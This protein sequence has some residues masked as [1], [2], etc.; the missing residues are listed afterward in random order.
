MVIASFST[1]SQNMLLHVLPPFF[2]FFFLPVLF[3]F[4]KIKPSSK[5]PKIKD[6]A[7][8]SAITLPK[9]YPLIGYYLAFKANAHRRIQWLSD[10]ILLSPAA[11][12]TL[13]R[14]LGRRTVVTAN[15]ASVQH[16][17]KTHFHV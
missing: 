11:T 12:F 3:F 1:Q 16:M 17:L 7:P 4:L 5:D 14:P 6:V 13:H 2:L 8:S 10:M 9:S 15:P